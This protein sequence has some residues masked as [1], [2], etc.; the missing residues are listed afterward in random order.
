MNHDDRRLM[1]GLATTL[2]KNP[3]SN[4]TEL[5]A[6]AG[7]SRA[8]LYRFSPTRE[9]I[10]SRLTAEAY[11]CLAEAMP[12]SFEEDPI[13]QLE[14][15]TRALVDDLELMLFLFQQLNADGVKRGDAFYEPPEWTA[16]YTRFDAFFLHGQKAGAFSIELPASWWTD[17]YW[18]CLFGAGWAMAT[19][20]IA[21]AA[22]LKAVMAS[23]LGGA[24]TGTRSTSGL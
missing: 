6:G 3:R 16:I 10:V 12:S 23:F 9:S 5:A 13:A 22:V 1:R 4:L 8:T 14:H 2:A 17:F 24:Q 7:I 11:A 19:G 20:R 18:S 21:H 15:M